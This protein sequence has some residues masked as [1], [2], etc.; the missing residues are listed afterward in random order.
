TNDEGLRPMRRHGTNDLGKSLML[1]AATLGVYACAAAAP[2]PRRAATTRVPAARAEYVPVAGLSR[3]AFHLESVDAAARYV[4]WGA[5][6]V[7]MRGRD[8][9]FAAPFTVD[10]LTTAVRL[11]SAW[12][13]VDEGGQILVGDSFVGELRAVGVVPDGWEIPADATESNGRLVLWRTNGDVLSTDGSGPLVP[14]RGVPAGGV[15][16]VVFTDALRGVLAGWDGRLSVTHDGGASFRAMD[17]GADVIVG[18]LVHAGEGMIT[19]RTTAGVRRIGADD[20]A[21]PAPDS[22]AIAPRDE[23]LDAS[24]RSAIVTAWIARTP[25]ALG[26]HAR[27]AT[28]ERWMLHDGALDRFDASGRLLSS[29]RVT[30]AVAACEVESWGTSMLARCSG[31]DG[32]R[33]FALQPDGTLGAEQPI[34]WDSLSDD[35]Q[36]AA[37]GGPCAGADRH[38]HAICVRTGDGHARDV[39]LPDS[40]RH[41]SS[42]G[43]LVLA[44]SLDH[45]DRDGAGGSVF[46]VDVERGTSAPVDLHAPEGPVRVYAARFTPAGAGAVVVVARPRTD[47]AHAVTYV[48][49]GMPDAPLTL[50]PLPAGATWVDFVDAQRGFAAGTD[51]RALFQTRDGGATWTPLHVSRH[52]GGGYPLGYAI[53]GGQ[54]TATMR[55]EADG[56]LVGRSFWLPAGGV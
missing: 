7:E 3:D 46:L 22:A 31:N 27:L 52:D 35:G 47:P 19:A 50:R 32:D 41:M 1:A 25:H 38:A 55:C 49:T 53:V 44:R 39:A 8:V 56:C 5:V 2:A 10:D 17:L 4:L 23:A 16:W 15:R 48:A 9:Q 33:L 42:R 28:G 36:H 13:F 40:V 18:D 26:R 43:G 20:V 54:W 30:P 21:V 11:G 29:H 6:R 45:D 34:D 14:M 24:A 12:L 51:S 37:F